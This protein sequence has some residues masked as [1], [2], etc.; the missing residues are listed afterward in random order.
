LER[1][2][3]FAVDAADKRNIASI[4]AIDIIIIVISC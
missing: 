3:K 1:G 2:G 4:T